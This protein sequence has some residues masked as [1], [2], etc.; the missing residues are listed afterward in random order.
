MPILVVRCLI[1]KG[2]DVTDGSSSQRAGYSCVCDGG[3]SALCFNAVLFGRRIGDHTID[4]PS[5]VPFR[6]VFRDR[7]SIFPYEQETVAIFIDLHLVACAD[8]SAQL[9]LGDFVLVEI[10]RTERFS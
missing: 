7:H 3:A 4:F 8:P 1:E 2:Y 9:G 5:F 10:A 6:Q